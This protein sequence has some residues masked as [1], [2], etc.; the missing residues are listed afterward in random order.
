MP[1]EQPI[2]AAK[3]LAL[4]TSN[5]R[6]PGVAASPAKAQSRQKKPAQ[7][8]SANMRAATELRL[9][10]HDSGLTQEE[11]AAVIGEGRKQV[12]RRERGE[13]WLGPLRQLVVLRHAAATKLKVVK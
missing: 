2:R 5:V 6:D 9:A 11:A 8:D 1:A 3:H 13:V 7:F 12:G 4:H 10:R